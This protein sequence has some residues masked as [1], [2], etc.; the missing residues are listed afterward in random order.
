MIH[1]IMNR[2]VRCIYVHDIGGDNKYKNIIINKNKKLSAGKVITFTK[3]I[4][5]GMSTK[6]YVCFWNFCLY[7]KMLK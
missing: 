7:K 2:L 3:Y 6:I 4:F 5:T 1:L